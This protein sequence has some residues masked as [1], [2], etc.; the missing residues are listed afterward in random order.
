MP[1]SLVSPPS[2]GGEV[3]AWEASACGGRAEKSRTSPPAPVNSRRAPEL[4]TNSSPS[5]PGGG[6]GGRGREAERAPSHRGTAARTPD[7][8][9]SLGAAS[10]SL[11]GGASILSGGPSP[12]RFP[13]SRP[14]CPHQTWDTCG[15][16]ARP[17]S[18]APV[19]PGGLTKTTG[20]ASGT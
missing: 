3:G 20:L 17:P 6:V 13:A 15:A 4:S 5:S 18:P 7:P 19:P 12:I 16:P 9:D 10:S 1:Q 2:A 14:T 8:A 11:T